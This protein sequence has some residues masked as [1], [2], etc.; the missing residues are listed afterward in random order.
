MAGSQTRTLPSVPAPAGRTR[1]FEVKAHT[2]LTLPRPGLSCLARGCPTPHYLAPLRSDPAHPFRF[3]PVGPPGLAQPGRPLP[4]PAARSARP[5]RPGW[6]WGGSCGPTARAAYSVRPAHPAWFAHAVD[7]SPGRPRRPG[8]PERSD[9]PP[10][11]AVHRP[12][13]PTRPGWAAPWWSAVVELRLPALD[14]IGR[15]PAVC[16]I[17]DRLLWVRPVARGRS[18]RGPPGGL[19]RAGLGVV[20]DLVG[21]SLAGAAGRRDRAAPACSGGWAAGSS[22][23]LHPPCLLHLASPRSV[24][25]RLTRLGP[26]CPA[27]P[28]HPSLLRPC[29][30]VEWGVAHLGWAGRGLLG[31]SGGWGEV[32]GCPGCGL[33]RGDVMCTV[34]RNRDYRNGCRGMRIFG[35][36][37]H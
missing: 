6:P 30:G 8:R 9:R 32:L 28:P 13:P 16:R 11:S 36:F 34:F 22:A 10:G 37:T 33:G 20:H 1:S 19:L 24:S 14:C 27:C 15:W 4:G 26:S 21:L 18:G 5:A 2:L 7:P 31:I 23:G 35:R 29:P 17:G 12:G 3:G 25:A